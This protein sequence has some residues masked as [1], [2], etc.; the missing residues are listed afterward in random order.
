MDYGDILSFI[1]HLVE[2]IEF[3]ELDLQ[4]VHTKLQDLI[5]EVENT[6]ET[7]EEFDFGSFD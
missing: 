3:D 7:N 1:E 4:E 5:V 2:G 6:I